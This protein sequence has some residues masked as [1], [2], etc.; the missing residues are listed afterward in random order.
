[1]KTAYKLGEES[2]Y[3]VHYEQQMEH[4]LDYTC[5]GIFDSFAEAQKWTVN[6]SIEDFPG[7]FKILPIRKVK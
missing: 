4:G 7:V 2:Q 5:Y 6:Q 1:M 3:I